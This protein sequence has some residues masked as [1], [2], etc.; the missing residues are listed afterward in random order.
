MPSFGDHSKQCAALWKGMSDSQK[1]PFL[2]QAKRDKKRH[3]REMKGYV[4]PPKGV[5]KKGAKKWKDP[6]APKRGLSAFF[7][8]SS[9]HRGMVQAANPRYGIGDVS[10]EL[11]RM[12]REMTPLAKAKYQTMAARDRARYVRDM[13]AYKNR[14]ASQAAGVAEEDE[15]DEEE[16]EEEQEEEDEEED[17]D[18]V[19]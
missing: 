9:E 5:G 17:D 1:E 4:P 2:E 11:G 13:E 3:E 6:N 18:E 10:K 14:T 15:D 12:W 19:D 7:W 8:Y 16:G